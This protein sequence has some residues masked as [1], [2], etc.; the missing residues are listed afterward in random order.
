M[1][2]KVLQ[3]FSQLITEF[4]TCLKQELDIGLKEVKPPIALPIDDRLKSLWKEVR[5]CKR[6][7]LADTRINLVFGEGNPDAD[8]MFI[9]E[10]PGYYEDREGRPFIGKA[11]Q[12]LTRIINAIGLTRKDVYITNIVKCHPLK[13]SHFPQRRGNDRA[14][15]LEEIAL[16][17]PILKKQINIISPKIICTLGNVATQTLLDTKNSMRSLRGHFHRITP[18]ITIMPTYHPAALLRNPFLKRDVWEDMKMI[19][20]ALDIQVDESFSKTINQD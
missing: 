12:L 5:G 19:M 16:C 15:D 14:P 20:R 9:G 7:R 3:N 11:G 10:G 6:C 4:K 18:N 8:L 1:R 2:N 13:D 17:L